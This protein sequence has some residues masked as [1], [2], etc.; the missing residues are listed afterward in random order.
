M[1]S[2]LCAS[3]ILRARFAA[4]VRIAWQPHA[5]VR[6]TRLRPWHMSCRLA[7][8]IL[9]AGN[10]LKRLSP[11]VL[12]VLR[13]GRVFACAPCVRRMM[14][15]PAHV[16]ARQHRDRT[17]LRRAAR[18]RSVAARRGSDDAARARGVCR[19]RD[20]ALAMALQ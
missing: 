15:S 7:L 11:Y 8:S 13:R 6:E 3:C 9:E 4:I 10:V 5:K 17:L 12:V 14:A 20:S 16:F 18:T 2:R 19:A 1:R